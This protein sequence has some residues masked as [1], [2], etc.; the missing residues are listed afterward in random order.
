MHQT[1]VD[2]QR[3]RQSKSLLILTQITLMC[4]AHTYYNLILYSIFDLELVN[5]NIIVE[6]IGLRGF[7]MSVEIAKD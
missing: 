6:V 2:R 3:V 1:I 4:T 5:V 7:L